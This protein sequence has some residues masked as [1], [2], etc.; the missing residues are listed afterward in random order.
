[1][2]EKLYDKPIS[3]YMVCLQKAVQDVQNLGIDH[4]EAAKLYRVQEH[5][6][7]KLE[8]ENNEYLRWCRSLRYYEH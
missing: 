6:V 1:M 2:I 3:D 7:R 4:H 8:Q 5:D